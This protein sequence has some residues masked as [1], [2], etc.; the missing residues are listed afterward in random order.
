MH[1]NRSAAVKDKSAG[2]KSVIEAVFRDTSLASALEPLARL[3]MVKNDRVAK[4][5]VKAIQRCLFQF[6]ASMARSYRNN[7]VVSFKYFNSASGQIEDTQ[8]I[9]VDVIPHLLHHLL[10]TT[11][12]RHRERAQLAFTVVLGAIQSFVRH[13]TSLG[14]PVN[15][16]FAPIK[17]FFKK[18][19]FETQMSEP[20]Y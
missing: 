9:L 16:V 8:V 3:L 5:V 20:S 7:Q 1:V 12:P 11:I 15:L 6:Q 4:V 10:L 19:L 18:V 17:E 14:L 2:L 13:S